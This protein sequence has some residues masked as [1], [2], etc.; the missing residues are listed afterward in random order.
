MDMADSSSA[1]AVRPALR[2]RLVIGGFVGAFTLSS[3]V[4]NDWYFS[5]LAAGLLAAVLVGVADAIVTPFALRTRRPAAVRVVL[6]MAIVVAVVFAVRLTDNRAFGIVFQS[7]LPD[8]VFNVV[9]ERHGYGGINRALL[10]QFWTDGATIAGLLQARE[11]E[12][13]LDVIR[14]WTGGFAGADTIWDHVFGA[15]LPDDHRWRRLPPP[16]NPYVYRS[17]DGKEPRVVV[18]WDP[19]V[20]AAHVIAT[21]D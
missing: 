20:G 16:V 21:T 9:A 5:K 6:A 3:F 1:K 13:D 12:V 10:M 15:S 2:T 7:G 14:A 18:L 19:D 8:D 17:G 4:S 11:F